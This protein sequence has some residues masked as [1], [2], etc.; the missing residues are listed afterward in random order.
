MN[1]TP[2]HQP[3]TE[4][5]KQLWLL[6]YAATSMEKAIQ[7]SCLIK[8]NCP[9]NQHV[10]F[11]P[12]IV[13]LHSYYARPFGPNFGVGRLEE[14]VIPD[15]QKCI[16]NFLIHFRNKVLSH[17]SALVS[18][19]VNRPMHDVVYSRKGGHR[20]FSTSCPSPTIENYEEV[21]RHCQFM[22]KIFR[23]KIIEF[24]SKYNK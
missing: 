23:L 20:E 9:N 10:L 12:L 1:P 7:C 13:A 4:E 17:A 15:A 18:P 21:S 11:E 2:L 5:R 22:H 16:H 24:A 3:D 6:C 8:M 19:E 14:D